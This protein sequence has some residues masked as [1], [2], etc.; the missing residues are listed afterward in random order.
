MRKP[1]QSYSKLSFFLALCLPLCIIIS[2]FFLAKP[3]SKNCG[4]IVLAFAGASMPEGSINMFKSDINGNSQVESVINQSN[5]EKPKTNQEEQQIT[6]NTQTFPYNQTQTPPDIL[7]LIEEAKEKQAKA[8][9]SGPIVEKDY[10]NANVTYS[11]GNVK[12]RNVTDTKSVNIKSTI[13][14]KADLAIPDKTK[15]TV[16]I[17]HTHTTEAYEILDRGWYSK[18]F[19]TRSK[20]PNTNMVRVGLAIKQ[21][22]EASGFVVLHDTD[23]HDTSYN[24]SYDRSRVCIEKYKKEYPTLK[25]I[26]DVHRD[27]IINKDGVKTKPVAKISGKKAAQIMIITGCQEGKVKEFKDWEQ[28]L[29]FALQ[30]QK[31]AE[32]LYPGLMRPVYFSPR[33]YNMDTSHCGVL[34]EMGSDAN[35]LEEAVYSGELIGNAMAS[36]MNDYV[37]S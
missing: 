36:L 18:D 1:R 20:N 35:T 5:I 14:Q 29:V 10:T 4:K 17:Y 23:I 37:A 32:D 34:L 2:A 25:V 31:K 12:V 33:K 19:N 21:R 16:L 8:S 13:A 30:L 6:Q 11:Y 28:N 7:K 24:G 9:K 22:L 27:G 26:I 15:P 3:F